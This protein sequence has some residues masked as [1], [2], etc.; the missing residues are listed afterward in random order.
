[1]G[2]EIVWTVLA[3]IGAVAAMR[4]T[5]LAFGDREAIKKIGVSDDDREIVARSNLRFGVVIALNEA[6]WFLLGALALFNTGLPR[7][8][9]LTLFLGFRAVF[10]VALV[11]NLRDRKRLLEE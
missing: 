6:N 2:I 7:A 4:M 10:V 11:L 9:T 3:A 8:V 1:M 5:W